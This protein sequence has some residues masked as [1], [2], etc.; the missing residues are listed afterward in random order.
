MA[1][2]SLTGAAPSAFY[3]QLIHTGTG[4]LAGGATL[5]LGDG[6]ATCLTL[7][8]AGLAVAG[9]ISATGSLTSAG[10][11]VVTGVQNLT[12]AGAKRGPGG[13]GE[14]TVSNA[15]K[16]II[17]SVKGHAKKDSDGTVTSVEFKA[18]LVDGDFA[19]DVVDAPEA[20]AFHTLRLH[21]GFDVEGTVANVPPKGAQ[22]KASKK[23]EGEFRPA[24]APAAP[25]GP[26]HRRG[27]GRYR[28]SD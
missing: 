20:L 14:P 19:G 4:T 7:S 16:V 1:T 28:W 17:N 21:Q 8:T 2:I 23:L 25:A 6:T 13:S 10:P 11:V 9:T 26:R 15:Y 3:T 5:R 22:A 27:G 18:A 12:G 24:P